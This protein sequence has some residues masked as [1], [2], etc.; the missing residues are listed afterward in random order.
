VIGSDKKPAIQHELLPVDDGE[1]L[2]NELAAFLHAV[3]TRSAPPV[4][5]PAG[6]RALE[7]GDTRPGID[8]K[9]G[10]GVTDAAGRLTAFLEG[11]VLRNVVPGVVWWVGAEPGSLSAGSLGMRR[12]KPERV[13]MAID[14]PFDLASLTKPLATGAPRDDP[15]R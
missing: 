13:P 11:E 12:S 4:D 15:S 1:P 8:R 2:A 10:V 7:L 6:R 5:G 9:L 14:T 3:R